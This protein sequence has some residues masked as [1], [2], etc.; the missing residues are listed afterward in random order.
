MKDQLLALLFWGRWEEGIFFGGGGFRE[1]V[2]V[3]EQVLP[4]PELVDY[5]NK[6]YRLYRDLYPA[7]RV[8]IP[9]CKSYRG[10]G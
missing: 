3:T 8:F 9:G 6:A 10:E 1:A 5:Y 2:K 4:S 7:L